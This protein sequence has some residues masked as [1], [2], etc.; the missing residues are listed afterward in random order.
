MF[1]QAFTRHARAR[2]GGV[3]MGA[4]LFAGA[5]PRERHTSRPARCA[6]VANRLRWRRPAR[7]N[8]VRED[9]SDFP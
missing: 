6:L 2:A 4:L 3:I 1:H 9:G 5:S 8:C 7:K